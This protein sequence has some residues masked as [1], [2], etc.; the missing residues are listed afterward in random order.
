MNEI[1]GGLDAFGSPKTDNMYH[2]G[3]AWAGP[4]PFKSTKLVAAHFGGTRTPLAVSWTKSIKPD[5]T[6]RSQFDHVNDVV[7]TIYDVLDIT[8]PK[9]VDGVTQNPMDGVNMASS[10]NNPKAPENKPN[11]Y[12]EIMGSRGFYKNGWFAA[13]FGPRIPWKQGVA[14]NVGRDGRRVV[15]YLRLLQL[16]PAVCTWMRHLARS[17]GCASYCFPGDRV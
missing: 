14:P 10:F 15:Y 9:M 4:T 7:P 12:F 2:A 16:E 13:D 3:W 17:S 5:K 6:P 8:P 11:R 1:G